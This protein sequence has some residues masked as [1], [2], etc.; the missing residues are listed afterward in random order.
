MHA[1]AYQCMHHLVVACPVGVSGHA[2]YCY[3]QRITE[4]E[5]GVEVLEAKAKPIKR[6]NACG[7]RRFMDD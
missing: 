2:C 5:A 1:S 7:S 4:R 3:F 6:F